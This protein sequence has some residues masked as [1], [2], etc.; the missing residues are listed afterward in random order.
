ME[1]IETYIVI[2]AHNQDYI[3]STVYMT[4]AESPNEAIINC[5][6]YNDLGIDDEEKYD[7]ELTRLRS[8]SLYELEQDDRDN[9]NVWS[10]R[11]FV[12]PNFSDNNFVVEIA[13]LDTD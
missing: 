5:M 12:L 6:E 9:G 8:L 11:I 3:S 10:A 4:K 13:E 2:K 1:N 7:A